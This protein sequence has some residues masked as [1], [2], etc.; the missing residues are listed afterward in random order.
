MIGRYIPPEPDPG[1][2]IPKDSMT[3]EELIASARVRLDNMCEEEREVMYALQRESYARSFASGLEDT[4]RRHAA[5]SDQSWQFAI[6]DKVYK[7]KG[8]WWEGFIV[9]TYSTEQTPR[10][11]CVQLNVPYGPIQIYPE[12]ALKLIRR[13]PE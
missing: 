4:Q 13:K 11:Y 2:L 12:A 1:S 5:Y 8:A 7:P 9:G 3:L 6:G 10:G